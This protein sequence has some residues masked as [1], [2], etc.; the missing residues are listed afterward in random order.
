MRA[1]VDR[2]DRVPATCTWELTLR[3][4]LNCGHCG[5]RA[6]APRDNEMPRD[7]MLGVVG[8]LAALGCK[9]ITLSGGEPTMCDSWTHVASEGARL[10]VKM[11][12]I[13]NAAHVGR[14]FVRKAKDSGLCNLGVSLDGLEQ[15]H[16]TL[17]GRRGLYRNVMQLLDDCAAEK[18][19]IG[20]ITTI[21]KRNFRQ[22]D[23]LHDVIAG[24]AFVWQLQTGAAM[25]NLHD[26]HVQIQPE[27][28]LEI[29]PALARL[30]QRGSKIQL[31]VADNV[32][33]YGPYE[34]ILRGS[35]ACPN[36]CWAGCYAGVRHIGIEADGGVKGCLSIQ[37][38]RATEGNLQKES[39]AEIWN[40]PGAFAYNRGFQLDDLTGFCRTCVHAEVC[41]GGCLSMRTCEGGR[42]N[43]FCYHR[44]ATLA[45]QAA[46]RSK[47]RY[48]PLMIAPAALMAL[49]G[50]GGEAEEGKDLYGMPPVEDAGEAATNTD[51]YGITTDAP[52]P[53]TNVEYYGVPAEAG[54][55]P[56]AIGDA[57][58]I[59]A[60]VYGVEAAPPTDAYGIMADA[61]YGIPDPDANVDFYGIMPD[62][63]PQDAA[64]EAT[65]LY[66]MD[67][68][69]K[70]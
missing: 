15:E 65:P 27:D 35:R 5:S 14:D 13:T 1:I 69:D 44:V 7:R 61:A 53:E 36:K 39:L 17:R 51:A 62:A 11:N 20:V 56:P 46:K 58:G 66:G 16:D 68:P 25:G 64:P 31:K 34:T 70:Q 43:P 38:S 57:Y 42:D 29:V 63:E 21:T 45:E 41:R 8:E 3:C 9:R 33:Y 26:R 67:P 4:N 30:I 48:K 47:P 37:S 18:L 52:G 2:L 24:R 40:R 12:M 32:G 59:S 54:D 22:L 50:C 60:D 6:G 10:G 23:E 55:E 49:A 19:S 28:L